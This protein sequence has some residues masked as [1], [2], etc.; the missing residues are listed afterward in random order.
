[1]SYIKFNDSEIKY[2]GSIM[3]F[4]TQHGISAITIGI[5]E[6]IPVNESG[7]KV[8]NDNNEIL[9]DFSEYNNHYEGNSYSIEKD[10]IEYGKGV[11]EPL[12]A[13]PFDNMAVALSNLTTQTYQNSSNIQEITPYIETK[14]A[15]IDDTEIVFE[16]EKQ[17]N[18]LVNAIDRE[19]NSIETSHKREGNKIIVNFKPLEQITKITITIQ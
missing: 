4:K 19:G 12:P 16:N 2:S 10:E 17:G 9:E 13:S 8:Y 5:S 15:Y 7:F 6:E 18:V 1:M 11:S 14:T 3:P